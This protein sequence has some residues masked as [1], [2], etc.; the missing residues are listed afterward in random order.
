LLALPNTPATVF[1]AAQI[2]ALLRAHGFLRVERPPMLWDMH[3]DDVL[4]IRVLGEMIAAALVRNGGDLGAVT[5]NV[6]NVST[7]VDPESTLPAGEFVALTIKGAGD[8][9]PEM[10]W[11][12]E[13]E[14]ATV[15]MSDDLTAAADVAGAAFGYTRVL[16]N[17]SGSVTLFFR[18]AGSE[19]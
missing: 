1:K 6:A 5:L 10:I 16:G 8:W 13:M 9:Q 19:C 12:P 15:L 11:H 2:E 3:A 14:V 17:H 7:P 18:R 4:L